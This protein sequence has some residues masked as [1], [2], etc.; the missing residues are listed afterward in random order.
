M[1]DNLKI[2][3]TFNGSVRYKIDKDNKYIIFDDGG[4]GKTVARYDDYYIY[5]MDGLFGNIV[6]VYRDGMVFEYNKDA[7]WG[8]E[9]DLVYYYEDGV[10]Y[11]STSLDNKG[12]KLATYESL[13]KEN[14]TYQEIKKDVSSITSSAIKLTKFDLICSLLGLPLLLVII[15]TLYNLYT[16]GIIN[17]D[18][19]TLLFTSPIACIIGEVITKLPLPL[20]EHY[21]KEETDNKLVNFLNTTSHL[22]RN[23][24]YGTLALIT[25]A[26]IINPKTITKLPLALK[27]TSLAYAL[28]SLTSLGLMGVARNKTT[29]KDEKNT[30]EII[31]KFKVEPKKENTTK[32]NTIKPNTIQNNQNTKKI[33]TSKINIQ[34]NN[35]SIIN[36]IKNK[37]FTYKTK[38]NLVL[39][40][41]L[42][43]IVDMYVDKNGM[44]LFI[45]PKT[46]KLIKKI[47]I[48]EY[49]NNIKNT[50]EL[51]NIYLTDNIT[52][53]I[54]MKEEYNK[55]K[56]IN[57]N[58][59]IKPSEYNSPYQDFMYYGDTL[60]NIKNT[61]YNIPLLADIYYNNRTLVFLQEKTTGFCINSKLIDYTDINYRNY[62]K[63]KQYLDNRNT[64]Y[65]SQALKVKSNIQDSMIIYPNNT[66]ILGYYIS[67][68]ND[69]KIIIEKT[70]ENNKIIFRELTSGTIIEE[71]IIKNMI[72][73][74]TLLTSENV[75]EILNNSMYNTNYKNKI[76]ILKNN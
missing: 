14:N 38:C 75:N 45:E 44:M 37:G 49:N 15:N 48:M 66:I 73:E 29:K 58:T 34:E 1:N 64:L 8:V 10:I 70:Y 43:V 41:N 67:Y 12:R 54:Y 36:E 62:E 71:D 61:I 42:N 18:F 32:Q 55:D 4:Y 28:P 23:C 74:K 56:R 72:L 30:E 63:S 5:D 52:D 39:K 27:Q 31:N 17:N 22:L 11:E 16:K 35:T 60:V 2:P 9:G 19:L 69:T 21:E 6:Y 40:N 76:K 26:I 7:F 20:N 68:L 59:D 51:E 33:D 25:L 57:L 46:K 65:E 47:Y 53:G 3:E 50:V 24:F 13:R